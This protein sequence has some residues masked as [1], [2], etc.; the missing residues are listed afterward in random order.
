MSGSGDVAKVNARLLLRDR[1]W[2]LAVV[3]GAAVQVVGWEAAEALFGDGRFDPFGILQN[4]VLLA[5][6]AVAAVAWTA[7]RGDPDPAD[8][9]RRDAHYDAVLDDAH[10]LRDRHAPFGRGV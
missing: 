8:E 2:W 9:V 7:W 1:A 10:A 3:A 6:G 5:A 4:A